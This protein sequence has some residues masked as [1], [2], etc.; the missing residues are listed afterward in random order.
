MLPTIADSSAPEVRDGKRRH[1]HSLS[2][3]PRVRETMSG[4]L[5]ED[6]QYGP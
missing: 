3:V 2:P 4:T 5:L 1:R 6:W